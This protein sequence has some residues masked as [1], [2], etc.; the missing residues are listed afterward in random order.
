MS[1]EIF[2]D[3]LNDTRADEGGRE[4]PGKLRVSG[5]IFFV[6]SVSSVRQSLRYHVYSPSEPGSTLLSE[7]MLNNKRYVSMLHM[8]HRIFDLFAP[9]PGQ[10]Q[11]F[12]R[13][14]AIYSASCANS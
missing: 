7:S 9:K 14:L 1:Y 12:A 2:R 3:Y 8:R 13:D 4:L 10:A 11:S 6:E 5:V